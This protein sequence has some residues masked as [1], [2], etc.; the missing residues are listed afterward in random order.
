MM[1][2]IYNF[3]LFNNYDINYYQLDLDFEETY[4]RKQNNK[5]IK[6]S[7]LD[8]IKNNPNFENY[9]DVVVSYGV[10]GF[11]LINDVNLFSKQL[12]HDLFYDTKTIKIVNDFV[13]EE[14]KSMARRLIRLGKSEPF[15]VQTIKK[16]GTI[17]IY[18]IDKHGIERKWVF[19]KN[20]G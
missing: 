5:L 16:D 18:P 12:V 17:W 14:Q 8:I 20:K 4:I 10:L 13:V 11:E 3:S 1:Y 7:M 19:S 9:F 15:E 6:S 2:N